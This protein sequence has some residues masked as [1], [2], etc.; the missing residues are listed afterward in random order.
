MQK[1][2]VLGVN[3]APYKDGVVMELLASVLQGAQSE[4]A[5]VDTINLYE[6]DSQFVKGAYS[7]DPGLETVAQTPK[8]GLTELYP[9]ILRGRRF[10]FGNS[11]LLGQ[12]ERGDERFY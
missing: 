2:F 12:Y 7:E 10:G 9:T 3:G 8:D 11:G 6:V 5:E 4:G 1:P